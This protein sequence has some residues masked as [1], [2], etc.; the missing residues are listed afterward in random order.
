MP[1]QPFIGYSGH[2]A[3]HPIWDLSILKR[4]D[5]AFR[6]LCSLHLHFIA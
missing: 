5:L 1:N 2:M 6:V 4:S 3:K